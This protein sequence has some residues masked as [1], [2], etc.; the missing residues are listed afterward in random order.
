MKITKSFILRALVCL[1]AVLMLVPVISISAVSEKT[2][3]IGY[4][5]Y[6]YW[7]NYTGKTRKA[8]YS[9]PMYEVS[10]V[11]TKSDLGCTEDS[12]IED[13]H[14]AKNGLTYVLDGGASCVIILDEN[15]E[16][17]NRF[18]FVVDEEDNY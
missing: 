13:V 3:E 6:T 17:R 12:V 14:T 15:Y 4:D 9:K 1:L 5:T 16:I 2:D 7:Y 11:F 10:K 18:N 8:V